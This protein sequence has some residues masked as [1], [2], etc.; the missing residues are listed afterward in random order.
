MD[1][2]PLPATDPKLHYEFTSNYRF[3]RAFFKL[4]GTFF[5]EFLVTALLLFPDAMFGTPVCKVLLMESKT[6]VF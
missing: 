2:S 6:I 4:A 3:A 1:P 5:A